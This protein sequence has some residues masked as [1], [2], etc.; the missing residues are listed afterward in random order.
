MTWNRFANRF[1]GPICQIRDWY[2]SDFE[3]VVPPCWFVGT[4]LPHRVIAPASDYDRLRGSGGSATLSAATAVAS[5]PWPYGSASSAERYVATLA[6]HAIEVFVPVGGPSTLPSAQ[7][8][9]N[10]L[11][12]VPARQRTHTRTVH[13]CPTAHPNSAPGRTIGGEAGSGVVTLF[14]YPSALTQ[15]VVDNLIMH[16]IGHNFQGSLW[17]SSAD[18]AVWTAAAARDTQSPS[19]YARENSGDDFCEFLIIFNTTRGTLCETSARTIFR[20]RWDQMLTY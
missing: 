5:H 12:A 20:H 10:A 16:E 2:E 9:C 6:G 3:A 4:A 13:L 17:Q 1:H 18:V 8:A 19:R 11:H 14:P 15:N 7:Q